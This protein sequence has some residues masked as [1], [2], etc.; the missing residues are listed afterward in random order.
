MRES[1]S[2]S[3]PIT[4]FMGT[5]MTWWRTC[6][7]FLCTLVYCDLWLVCGLESVQLSSVNFRNESFWTELSRN[8]H[9]NNELDFGVLHNSFDVP[10]DRANMIKKLMT[11]EG[12]VQLDGLPWD[13]PLESM[14]ELIDKLHALGLPITFCY[15]FDEFWYIFSRLHLSIESILGKNYQRLPDFWA[16]RVD[17]ANDEQGWN[18]HR[19]KDYETLFVNGTP[20]TVTVW[21]PLTDATILNSCMYILPANHDPIYRYSNNRNCWS[22]FTWFSALVPEDITLVFNL[23][24]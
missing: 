13:L 23:V 5:T 7:V 3:H 17:P 1:S 9:I 14:V 24:T 11:K 18:V 4:V 15:L 22:T 6:L 12:Y 10:L 8:L 19:D 21:I 16:W 2:L 20:K